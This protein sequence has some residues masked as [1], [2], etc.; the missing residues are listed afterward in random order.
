MLFLSSELSA[1]SDALYTFYR[2]HPWL[3]GTALAA[4]LRAA[5]LVPAFFV[6]AVALLTGRAAEHDMLRLCGAQA[7]TA[8]DASRALVVLSAGG[9]CGDEDWLADAIL[10]AWPVE[11][12]SGPALRR[13]WE[14]AAELSCVCLDRGRVEDARCCPGLTLVGRLHAN[15]PDVLRRLHC[16][17]LLP[18]PELALLLS[19]VAGLWR[20][21]M[22]RGHAT[23]EASSPSRAC[24]QWRPNR[25][26][27]SQA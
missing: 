20:Q 12:L 6:P 13:V 8:S 16:A 25:A 26:V 1:R 14:R 11:A 27:C 7:L 15:R 22:L 3:R 18:G 21:A 17:G 4:G 2:L 24:G 5:T 9:P 10:S 23:L 19:I